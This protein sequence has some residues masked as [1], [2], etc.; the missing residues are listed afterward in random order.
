MKHDT[1]NGMFVCASCKR[2]EALHECVGVLAIVI[3]LI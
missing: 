3:R 2:Y 1:L